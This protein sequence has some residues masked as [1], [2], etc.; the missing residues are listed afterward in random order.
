MPAG[1]V[2]SPR[3]GMP[4][5]GAVRDKGQ[6]R[7]VRGRRQMEGETVN[8]N[9]PVRPIEEAQ[10]IVRPL[11]PQ[12]RNIHQLVGV[13]VFLPE[14]VHQQPSAVE[15]GRGAREG[16]KNERLPVRRQH[17]FA[18]GLLPLL[19]A[20]IEAEPQATRG[21]FAL[22][23]MPHLPIERPHLGGPMEAVAVDGAVDVAVVAMETLRE[24]TGLVHPV[25]RVRPHHRLRIRHSVEQRRKGSRHNQF[26]T[27]VCVKSGLPQRRQQRAY[28]AKATQ[29]LIYLGRTDTHDNARIKVVEMMER[30]NTATSKASAS[31]SLWEE[32]MKNREANAPRAHTAK[33]ILSAGVIRWC[34]ETPR[35]VRRGAE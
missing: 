2:G 1:V 28:V 15:G 30:A 4:W 27:V 8:G 21:N 5:G 29:Q 34:G 33:M 25:E 22:R 17:L 11:C 20:T 10:Q 12:G 19:G 13:A 24:V 23:P 18:E 7:H 35:Q 26:R 3:G 32:Q 9:E 16:R 6:R 31:S 14:G